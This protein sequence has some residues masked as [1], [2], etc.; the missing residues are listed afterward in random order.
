MSH[1]DTERLQKLCALG[2]ISSSLA[3]TL[4]HWTYVQE[5][6]RGYVAGT[7]SVAEHHFLVHFGQYIGNNE[8]VFALLSGMIAIDFPWYYIQRRASLPA[9]TEASLA[10]A[11]EK[12][13]PAIWM[14][15]TLALLVDAETSQMVAPLI[16]NFLSKFSL[17]TQ[18]LHTLFLLIQGT[19]V[20]ADILGGLFGAATFLPAYALYRKYIRADLADMLDAFVQLCSGVRAPSN[21]EAVE[22][23]DNSATS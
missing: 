16:L 2:A 20:E 19:P 18:T 10:L 3:T 17:S 4:L 8:T 7:L 9:G 22:S 14:V 12:L 6:A 21:Q 11:R 15:L 23:L 13:L 1:K 5:L